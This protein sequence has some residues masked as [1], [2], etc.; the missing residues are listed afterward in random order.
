MKTWMT[1][2]LLVFTARLHAQGFAPASLSNQIYTVVV[3]GG[4]GVFATSGIASKVFLAN[5]QAV[6]LD[7]SGDI[8]LDQR[9]AYTYTKTGANSG[10]IVQ[11]LANGTI[12]T[13]ALLTFTSP[14][15]GTYSASVVS[16]GTGTQTASFSLAPSTQPPLVN[17][18]TR[19]NVSQGGQ[20]IAGFVV[21]GT[22]AARVLVRAIGP[23]LGAF[24]VSGPMSSPRLQIFRSGA[25]TALAT[26]DAWGTPST[27]APALRTAFSAVGAFSLTDGS[28]DSALILTLEP[29]AYT[30]VVT[31]GSS[32]D[33]GEVLTEVYL[34]P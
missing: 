4:T 17:L 33:A 5:G 28:R 25:S 3:S 14:V 29:G 20:S 7:S 1:L 15:T 21:S 8:Q 23:T 26:R 10:T 16:G 32:A 19:T 13:Q 2:A 11:A 12:T 9:A 27:D 24:G 30:A 6:V 34:Y 31:G 22:A 18:S